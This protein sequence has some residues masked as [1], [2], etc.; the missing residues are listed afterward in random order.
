MII[1]I[2]GGYIS[3]TRANTPGI[4]EI[5]GYR[6]TYIPRYGRQVTKFVHK[7]ARAVNL[8][9]LGRRMPAIARASYPASTVL[10]PG[11]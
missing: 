5:L 2:L 11:C 7:L 10:T 1:I 8:N 6:Y 4:Y 9:R 3:L